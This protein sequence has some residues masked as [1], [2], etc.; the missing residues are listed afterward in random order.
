MISAL[1]MLMARGA[2]ISMTVV[3]LVLP[4]MFLIFDGL[5]CHTSMGFRKKRERKEN[6]VGELQNL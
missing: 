4:S 6:I 2:I 3:L 1:C 5:I